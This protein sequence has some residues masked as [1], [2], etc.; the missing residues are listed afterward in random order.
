MPKPFSLIDK[1]NFCF[2]ANSDLSSFVFFPFFF[3]LLLSIIDKETI[4]SLDANSIP[5]IPFE[6]LP[7]K[8]LNYFASNRIHLQN[9]VIIPNDWKN[10][11]LSS[12]WDYVKKI[13]D[14]ANI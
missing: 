6:D 8:T 13:R 5:F 12:N 2:A 14:E 7:L 3:N 10:E 11:K 9:F 4:S 1:I